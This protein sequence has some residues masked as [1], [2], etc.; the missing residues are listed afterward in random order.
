MV[1]VD[2]SGYLGFLNIGR[3]DTTRILTGNVFI[4]TKMTFFYTVSA[5]SAG[6]IV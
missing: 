3:W 4:F 5:V 6:L 2:A 1:L